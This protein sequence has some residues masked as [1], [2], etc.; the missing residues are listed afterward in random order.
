MSGY[1]SAE[2]VEVRCWG[3]R[4]GA[5]AADP[6]V[7]AYVFEYAP[8]WADAN[9]ELAPLHLPNRRGPY[10]FADLDRDTWKGLPPL[11]AD[12]LPDDFGNALV[13]AWM[14][15]QGIEPGRIT[16]LDRLAYTGERGLGA[17]TYH[18]PA[19]ERTEGPT[20]IA[21]AELVAS[22]RQVLAGEFPDGAPAEEA[23]RQLIQVGS[24]A[25]G[26]RAKAVVAFNPDTFQIRSGQFDAPPGFSHWL[27]KLDGVAMG[28]DRGV[29]IGDGKEYGRIEYGYHL[30]AAEAG[31][32][33]TDCR[34]LPEGPRAHFMTRRFDRAADG[35]RRHLVSLCGLAHLDFRRPGV[36]SY[37]QLLLTVDE[38]G[39]GPEARAEVFRRCVFNVAAVN[40]EDHTKNT[41]F[42]CTPEGEWS[43][44][45][46]FD[47]THSYRVDSVWVARHQMSVNGRTEGIAIADFDEV[48]DRFAVPGYR[49][50][51]REVL[52]AV[53]RWEEFAEASGVSEPT[54][55][56]IRADM[57]AFA[58]R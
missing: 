18:P 35:G 15:R 28:T 1:V 8:E 46:A 29:R 41:A 40:R 34:L 50:I 53:A 17:L 4:V 49:S 3:R 52:A 51:V 14:A 25:G 9:V 44:A 24:S 31:I 30:M 5:V 57:S 7:R 19:A 6:G 2:V 16:A 48:G 36:N 12:S 37:E 39:L 32:A 23:L 11:L 55:A 26:A 21:L 10:V 13:D 20:A 27:I 33:M 42:L 43:L 58:P 56:S 54:A 38:L 47:L 45:P 22:A